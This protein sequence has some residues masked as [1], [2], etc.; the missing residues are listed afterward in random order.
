[1]AGLGGIESR[2]HCSGQK[3]TLTYPDKACKVIRDWDWGAGEVWRGLTA[4]IREDGEA[5]DTGQR[6]RR[7]LRFLALGF[8]IVN[9][10]FPKWG[11]HIYYGPSYWGPPKRYP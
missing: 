4:M 7:F 8:K 3:V 10:S 6:L 5:K 9:G 11:T 2:A 1:M